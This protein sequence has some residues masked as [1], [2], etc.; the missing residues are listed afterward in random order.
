MVSHTILTI[1]PGGVLMEETGH[2]DCATHQWIST[3]AKPA[4][5][6]TLSPSIIS[7][8]MSLPTPDAGPSGSHNTHA[9]LSPS[10]SKCWSNCTAAPSM[11][12]AN[13]H[14]VPKD[15]SS[16][17]SREGT[18]AHDWAAK[19]LL[20]Q[21]ALSDVPEDFRPHVKLYLDHC[22]AT[23]PEGVSYQVEVACPLFYQ[24]SE[25]GTCDF[26]VITD[27]RV[28]IRDL[29]Y[30]MGVLVHAEGNSQL[31]IY[32]MSLVKLMED[33]YDFTPET[34][35]DIAP[36]QPR[37]READEVEPW[38]ISLAELEKFCADIDYRAIQA[39][40]GLERVR[41]KLPCGQR[42]I[43]A[44]EI[45]EAAPMVKFNPEEGDDGACRWCRVKA[46]CE[47]RLAANVEDLGL[48]DLSG[49]EL[50][51]LLPDLSKQELKAPVE[52][53]IEA[54]AVE[55]C[56]DTEILPSVI[57]A[58]AYLVAIHSK[59]K[60]IRRF[61]DDV[62][63]HLT[64]KAQGGSPV[65]G[66]KLVLGREG[67]RAWANEE[68]ADVFLKGQRLKE[69]ERYNFKL[70]SP[71]QIE[72]LLKDKLAASTRTANRFSALVSR[73]PAKP[74]LAFADDKREAITAPVD[75]LPD[76][77]TEDDDV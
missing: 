54:V 30:G 15:S 71:T 50:I 9:R 67:N 75:C 34:V 58:D 26:A 4:T 25:S 76:L 55:V 32:A 65:P 49:E 51:G 64:A 41:A 1:R 16:A 43:A 45:L 62:E 52:E 37:H 33:V 10:H 42:D 39:N 72:A 46:F 61:L 56:A 47:I 40:T 20:H 22:L 6:H 21:C 77:S 38:V 59:A 5:R 73:S 2:Y 63:E 7:C 36:F 29:K 27:E 35:V 66:T 53:R 74:V 70:K 44:S 11:L 13:S 18:E 17:F 24:L 3:S 19:V 31:A 57:L 60:A 28:V 23:V 8:H 68:E 12:E 48:P 69:S 14:R